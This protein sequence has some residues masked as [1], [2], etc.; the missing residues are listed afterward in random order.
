MYDNYQSIIP[1]FLLNFL[2]AVT[3]CFHIGTEKKK[4][5]RCGSI[6]LQKNSYIY[7]NFVI[8]R[9]NQNESIRKTQ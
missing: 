3:R 7:E 6:G 1:N 4:I 2:N 9:M 8:K 5:F